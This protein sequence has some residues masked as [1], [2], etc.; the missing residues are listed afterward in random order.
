MEGA[1]GSQS[2]NGSTYSSSGSED[3]TKKKVR[4]VLP[5]LDNDHHLPVSKVTKIM[6]QALPPK[7]HITKEA[8]EVIR[9]C[10][11][12]HIHLVTANANIGYKQDNRKK[13][14][15]EDVI[16][17]IVRIGLE[18]YVEPLTLYL[19]EYR[20]MKQNCG[21][22]LAKGSGKKRH[23][24]DVNDS[25]ENDDTGNSNANPSKDDD[26]EPSSLHHPWLK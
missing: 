5:A 3:P 6:H 23:S 16:S 18:D 2:S 26:A 1:E 19:N 25:L 20:G 14:S 4:Q 21:F 8:I 17:A 12:N 13:V 7:T 10:T 9:H 24:M 15:A 11:T 22:L